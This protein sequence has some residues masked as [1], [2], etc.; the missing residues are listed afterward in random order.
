[1][2]SLFQLSRREWEFL[3]FNLVFK[4][5]TGSFFLSVSCSRHEREFL[6]SIVGF[7]T[8][9]RF[10][11]YY[12]SHENVRECKF[13]LFSGLIFKKKTVLFNFVIQYENENIFLSILCFE[14]RTRKRK[15]FLH[16]GW[17]KRKLNL[18]RIFENE[19]SCRALSGTTIAHMSFLTLEKTILLIS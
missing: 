3:L 4:D 16:I 9:T 13:L 17:E 14:T 19:N 12:N 1:M 8:R 15:W 2:R 11:N 6:L 5:K 10:K 7:E 18:T